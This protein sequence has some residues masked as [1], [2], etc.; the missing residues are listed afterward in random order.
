[1]RSTASVDTTH[2]RPA[3]VA[4][5]SISA[6]LLQAIKLN[7]C[8]DIRVVRIT[9]VYQICLIRI[10]FEEHFQNISRAE[11][12]GKILIRALKIQEKF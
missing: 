1:M 9:P 8:R 10:K 6:R 4:Q 11:N 5:K 3:S 7:L 2:I 12:S